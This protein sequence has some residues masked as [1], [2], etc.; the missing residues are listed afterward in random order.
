[1]GLQVHIYI[2]EA[3]D[4]GSLSSWDVNLTEKIHYEN[5]VVIDSGD[6]DA[7]VPVTGTRYTLRKLGFKTIEKW[8]PWY[9]RRQVLNQTL[10]PNYSSRFESP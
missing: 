3:I 2:P 1:M 10:A 7:R 8:T 6:A 9:N 5:C 4:I